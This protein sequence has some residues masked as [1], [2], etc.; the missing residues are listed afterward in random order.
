MRE[1]AAGRAAPRVQR[2][3]REDQEKWSQAVRA[4]RVR[5]LANRER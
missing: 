5:A 3:S 2:R 1:A 4:L